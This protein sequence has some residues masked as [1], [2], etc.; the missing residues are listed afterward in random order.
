MC[1][2]IYQPAGT[3]LLPRETIE[4]AMADNPHGAGYMF[5]VDGRVAVRKAYWSVDELYAS[6]AAERE[7]CQSPFVLHFRLRTH[8]AMDERNTHPHSVC[9]GHI[10]VAHNGILPVEPEDDDDSDTI[11]YLETVFW[12]RPESQLMGSKF[13]DQVARHCGHSKFVLLCRD[14]RV[15]IINEH[16]GKWDDGCWYSS[17]AGKPGFCGS[18]KQTQ[19]YLWSAFADD[20]DD[21]DDVSP[22]RD[23]DGRAELRAYYDDDDE[24]YVEA[25]EYVDTLL[26]SEDP[27]TVRRII[28][29]EIMNLRGYR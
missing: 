7:L 4:L 25:L 3:D 18:R 1:L 21:L 17:H 2:I 27:A 5:C 15:S 11:A 8:G 22:A 19:Q 23:S 20:D 9:N 14:G 12:G 29:D 10:G 28:E 16:F 24:G 13:A 6:Y 26:D